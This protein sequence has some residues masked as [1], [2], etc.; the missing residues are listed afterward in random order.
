[1]QHAL[2]ALGAVHQNQ[3]EEPFSLP[4]LSSTLYRKA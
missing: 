2:G 1:M 4:R 3:E